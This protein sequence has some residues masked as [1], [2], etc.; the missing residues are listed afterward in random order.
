MSS[1]LFV[2]ENLASEQAFFLHELGNMTALP[3]FEA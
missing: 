2:R 1:S 3:L